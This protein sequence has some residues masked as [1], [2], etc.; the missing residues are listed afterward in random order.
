MPPATGQV[1][2]ATARDLGIDATAGKKRVMKTRLK[3]VAKA[4]KRTGRI[5]RMRKWA[6]VAVLIPTDVECY[7]VAALD[8][9]TRPCSGSVGESRR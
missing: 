3:R 9:A 6:G 4:A 1:I 7:F 8:S 5:V 2:A